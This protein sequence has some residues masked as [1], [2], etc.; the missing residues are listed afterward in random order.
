MYVFVVNDYRGAGGHRDGR[1]RGYLELAMDRQL[2]QACITNVSFPGSVARLRGM[3]RKNAAVRPDWYLDF[4]VL[5]SYDP[6]TGYEWTTGPWLRNGDFI[7]FY[8]A[9]G[10]TARIAKLS[11]GRCGAL[12]EALRRAADFSEQYAGTIF[13]YGKMSAN[14]GRDGRYAGGNHFKTQACAP[15]EYVRMLPHPL[16]EADWCAFLQIKRRGAVTPLM[17]WQARRLRGLAT[18]LGVPDKALSRARFGCQELGRVGKASWRRA[19]AVPQRFCHEHHVREYIAEFILA[20]LADPGSSVLQECRCFRGGRYVGQVDFFARIAG[21]WVPA[22]VKLDAG[23][24]P[25]GLMRT[26]LQRYVAV[27]TCAPVLGTYRGRE[28]GADGVD[29][30]LVIDRY[31]VYA[32]KKGRFVKC[33][34]GRPRW[35]VASLDDAAVCNARAVVGALSASNAPARE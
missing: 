2:K 10:A 12:G 29:V 7:F 28:H 32:T 20:E 6:E 1:M 26:Q 13:A 5:H 34:P 3:V 22:E 15:C 8:H 4:D 14:A 23:R 24:V 9:K 35:P 30:V 16:E 17:S 11:G 27:E 31:G 21:T 25:A 18:S 19:A 33:A